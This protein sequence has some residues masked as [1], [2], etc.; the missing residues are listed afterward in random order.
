MLAVQSFVYA[1]VS[2]VRQ[3]I[4]VCNSK[5]LVGITCAYYLVYPCAASFSPLLRVPN[6]PYVAS[7]LVPSLFVGSDVTICNSN[8]TVTLIFSMLEVPHYF[9]VF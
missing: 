3:K 5:L 1:M 7:T 9:M 2:L 4:L 8:L 6:Q